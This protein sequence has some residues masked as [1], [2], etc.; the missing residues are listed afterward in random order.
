MNMSKKWQNSIFQNGWKSSRQCPAHQ[1]GKSK[2]FACAKSLRTSR[3]N[4]ADT[5]R[6]F[7]LQGTRVAAQSADAARRRNCRIMRSLHT[8]LR[9]RMGKPWPTSGNQPVEAIPT[10]PMGR[11]P[12]A[13]PSNSGSPGSA[14]RPQHP[15]I[16][17]NCL[18]QGASQPKSGALASGCN[19]F[20]T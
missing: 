6:S 8:N 11:R 17:H 5:G 12:G 2:N 15:G 14:G 13:S 10:V 16:S 4:D 20:R 1:V 19:L 7:D 9:R 18:V 3:Y